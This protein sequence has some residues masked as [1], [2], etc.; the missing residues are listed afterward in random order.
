[1]R[2]DQLSISN[3][4]NIQQASLSG[5]AKLNIFIGNNGS[6]KTSLLEAIYLLSSAKS[7]RSQRIQHVVRHGASNGLVVAKCDDGGVLGVDK[8]IDGNTVIKYSGETIRSAFQLADILPIQLINDE[9]FQLLTAGPQTRRQLMDWGVFHVEHQFHA[10]WTQCQKSLKQ[11]N[12]LLRQYKGQTPMALLK[13]WTDALCESSLL[14]D[15]LR[16]SWFEKFHAMIMP[17]LQQ[18]LPAVTDISF[19]Y[20][21]GWDR[22][23]GLADCLEDGLDTDMQRGFTHYGPQRADIRVKVGGRPAE[24]VLSR[25]QQKLVVAAMKVA[26]QRVLEAIGKR[27]SYVIDD[28]AAELDAENA[29]NLLNLILGGTGIQQVFMTAIEVTDIPAINKNALENLAMF[30]VEH[31]TISP[32]EG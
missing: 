20:Y 32:A 19:S 21:C 24:D 27:S 22:V 10:A 18:L 16:D 14:L 23:R 12:A 4:R 7:F 25:G 15:A 6:G 30:H 29:K 5:L 3:F 9:S 28:I 11:R 31:G 13:P 1:M 17:I 26:Q 2:I 8:N